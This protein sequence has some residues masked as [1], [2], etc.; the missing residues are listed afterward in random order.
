MLVILVQLAIIVKLRI[1]L[2]ELLIELLQRAAASALRGLHNAIRGRCGRLLFCLLVFQRLVLASATASGVAGSQG[3]VEPSSGPEARSSAI[4]DSLLMLP[5]PV[6]VE[7]D[8]STPRKHCLRLSDLVPPPSPQGVC[9]R[10]EDCIAPPNCNLHCE[11]EA[12]VD[13]VHRIQ[14][15]WEPHDL[16]LTLQ[17]F[18]AAQA[19]PVAK[20][21]DPQRGSPHFVRLAH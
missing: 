10:L 3:L 9:L 2:E 20:Y 1:L 5:T 6:C 21:V 7:P 16:N 13:L 8:R 19:P 12:F 17:G 18:A 4:P 11:W 14:M 15:P